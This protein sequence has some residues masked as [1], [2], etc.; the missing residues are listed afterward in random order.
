MS[1]DT[2]ISGVKITRYERLTNT[3]NGNPRFRITFDNAETYTTQSDTGWVYECQNP[4]YR[5]A[6]LNV[7]LTPAGRI[8]YAR[9]IQA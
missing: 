8:R 3:V 9:V 6:A 4:Q 7:T 1:K 5:D 2:V